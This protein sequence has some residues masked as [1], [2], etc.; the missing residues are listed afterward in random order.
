MKRVIFVLAMLFSF[1]AQASIYSSD[2]VEEVIVVGAKVYNGYSDP[3][4]D[5]HALEA[6][7]PTKRFAPGGKGGFIGANINGMDVKHT[8]VWKN[9]VPAN[10]PSS[11]WYDFG[12][13]LVAQQYVKFISGPN[14][15]RYGSGSIAG[16]I[17]I[18]DTFEN[19]S[20]IHI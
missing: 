19:L 8:S 1:S 12:T 14:S 7:M 17:I 9:G 18:E 20:L 13:D 5:E 6:V 2:E 16:A 10:D 11:G 15:V 4:Y 3:V